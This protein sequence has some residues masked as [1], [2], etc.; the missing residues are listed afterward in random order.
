MLTGAGIG[1]KYENADSFGDNVFESKS[2]HDHVVEVT[3]YAAAF[4][5]GDD[6]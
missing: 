2:K 6:R 4:V 3:W 1:P 5:G